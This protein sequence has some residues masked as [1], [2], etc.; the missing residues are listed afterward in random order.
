MCVCGCVCECARACAH[1][2]VGYKIWFFMNKN[3]WIP[4]VIL[5]SF[6]TG[7]EKDNAPWLENRYNNTCSLCGVDCISN[8]EL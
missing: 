2:T 6:K 7:P 3:R 5:N 8:L 1:V 4:R